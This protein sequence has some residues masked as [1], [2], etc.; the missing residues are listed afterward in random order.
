ML[1]SRAAAAQPIFCSSSP[2]Q[3]RLTKHRCMTN[4]LQTCPGGLL[5][6]QV[7]PGP[8]RGASELALARRSGGRVDWRWRTSLA[9][10]NRANA[11]PRSPLRLS[12]QPVSALSNAS[13]VGKKCDFIPEHSPL[14]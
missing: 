13:F 5:P 10:N 14:R 3:L 2:T 8:D 7:R 12:Q 1:T 9:R 11:F 4:S 6:G